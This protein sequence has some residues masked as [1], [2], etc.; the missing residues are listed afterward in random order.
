MNFLEK[1]RALQRKSFG[2][3]P[4][5]ITGEDRVKYIRMNSLAAIAELIEALNE[6]DGWKD[7]QTERENAG[8]FKSWE[9]Y[10]GE[11][12]DV[13]HFVANL[14]NASGITEEM[15]RYLFEKKQEENARRQRDGYKGVGIDCSHKSENEFFENAP[16]WIPQPQVIA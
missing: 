1:Q 3:D 16:S 11:M 14:L 12:V 2:V 6:V 8:S 7:W 13:L 4:H 9:N 15:L 10:V 5:T